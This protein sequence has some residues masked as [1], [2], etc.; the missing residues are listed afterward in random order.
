MSIYA[1][2]DVIDLDLSST[3]KLVLICL[4]SR[5][6]NKEYK[7][8]N[9]DQVVL[10]SYT[11]LATETGLSSR[12]VMNVIDRL[13]GKKLLECETKGGGRGRSNVY[14]LI[15]RN[16]ESCSHLPVEK[17]EAASLISGENSEVDA[18]KGEPSAFTPNNQDIHQAVGSEQS[19]S[20]P[21]V[22]SIPLKDGSE[23][24][25]SAKQIEEWVKAYPAIDVRQELA[26]IRQWNVAN[27]NKRK[28]QN[29]V[30]RHITGWLNKEQDARAQKSE[31][32]DFMVGAV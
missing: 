30:L 17:G 8:R 16:S 14:K 13:I 18:K 9:S 21:E 20:Q 24:E 4:A 5:L 26:V 27:P 15:I 25:V 28:T 6:D 19:S 22:I 31:P 32:P 29:G 7:H 1:I 23:Y 2:K 10:A 3:E 11:R 12:A